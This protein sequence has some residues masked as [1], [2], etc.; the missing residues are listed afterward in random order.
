MDKNSFFA[1]TMHTPD[2]P[3]RAELRATLREISKS[4]IPLHRHLIDAAKS[5][6]AFAYEA[7]VSPTQLVNLLQDDPF[8]AWLKPLTS[9]IV[10]I[11]EMA[12]TDFEDAAAHAIP[13]RIEQIF[14]GDQYVAMLQRDVEVAGAHAGVRKT[15]QRLESRK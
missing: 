4:L 2:S 6:Y 14:A 13:T 1:R 8:F 11:D 15:L 5:D 12:R 3:E 9:V 7:D 10:D